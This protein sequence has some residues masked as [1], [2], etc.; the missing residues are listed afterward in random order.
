LVVEGPGEVVDGFL[1]VFDHLCH[2]LRADVVMEEVVQM[3]L[4]RHGLVQKLLVELLLRRMAQDHGLPDRV[5]GLASGAAHHLQ[6]VSDGIVA[7]AMLAPVV[8]LRAHD[9]HEVGGEGHAPA[10]V[11]RAHDHQRSA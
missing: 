3:A 2:D 4:D 7:V 5:L 11:A 10:H 8:E 9:H 1:L 6:Y